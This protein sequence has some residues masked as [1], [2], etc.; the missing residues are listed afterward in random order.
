MRKKKQLVPTTTFIREVKHIKLTALGMVP[1]Y[2]AGCGASERQIIQA[3]HLIAK[4][5]PELFISSIFLQELG[6][7]PRSWPYP[8]PGESRCASNTFEPLAPCGCQIRQQAPPP[9]RSLPFPPD[10]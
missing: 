2:S 10:C 1:C 8:Q 5:L 6:C 3:L 9:P 4:E 7:L